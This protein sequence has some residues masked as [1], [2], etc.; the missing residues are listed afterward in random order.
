MQPGREFRVY[1]LGF[2]VST[3]TS[4]LGFRA[5][6]EPPHLFFVEVGASALLRRGVSLHRGSLAPVVLALCVVACH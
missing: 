3:C 1:G 5:R 6:N 2:R 4:T